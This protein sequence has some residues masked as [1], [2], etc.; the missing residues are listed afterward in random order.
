[1]TGAPEAP[2][3]SLLSARG[4]K[5]LEFLESNRAR[6]LAWLALAIYLLGLGV[7]AALR[8]QGDF[9]IYY[10][11]GERVLAGLPIYP[12]DD[13]DRFLYAPIFAVG[14]APFALLPRWLA[15]LAFFALNAWG[16]TAFLIGSGIALFGRERVLSAPLIAGPVVL[17]CIF[18]GNNIEHGQINL[19]VLAL[20]AWAIVRAREGRAA[21]SGAMIAAAGLIKPFAILAALYLLWRRRFASILWAALAVAIL[22]AAPIAVFGIHGT[23][24]QTSA[25]VQSI[26]SMS[27]RFR[28]M[29]TNQSAVAMVSRLMAAMAGNEAVASG[30]FP[31]IEGMVLELL[32]AVSVF[33]R[34]RDDSATDETANDRFGLAMLFALMAGF[35]PIS[36]KS[37]FAALLVPYML[38]LDE[39]ALARS[40]PRSGYVP[41]AWLLLAL[42]ALLNFVPGRQVNRLAL[43]YSS[44]FWSSFC[45][46]LAVGCLYSDRRSAGA[47]ELA[48][49][50]A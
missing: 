5:L 44:T 35:A 6:R 32:F 11:S 37:Y 19:I 42:S 16:L 47:P 50:A 22:L 17:S 2:R 21:S 36:W 18:I 38:L 28:T 30:R 29:I 39:L 12:P 48:R 1:M 20:C 27:D 25:Y 31:L 26:L 3:G 23:I 4:L 10:R 45:V 46:L 33:L 49:P 7:S 24:D 34:L 14:F 8:V 40:E 15:Q 43:F 41:L 9:A 13:A